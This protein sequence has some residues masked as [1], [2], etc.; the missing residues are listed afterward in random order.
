AEMPDIVVGHVQTPYAGSYLG[1]KGA[2]EAGAAAAPAAILNAVNDALAPHGAM[3]EALPITPVAV[4]RA[5][6]EGS[7]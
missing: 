2:G 6:G 7:A 4:L 1:A 5:L 3:L